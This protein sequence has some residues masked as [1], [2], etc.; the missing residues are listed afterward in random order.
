MNELI[1]FTN[2]EF[3]KLRTIETDKGVYFVGKDV[4]QALGYKNSRQ[5]IL[6]NVNEKDRGSLFSR[7]P[8]RGTANVGN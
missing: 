7:H 8:V 2:A 3:G 1:T 6:H 5:A 4:A